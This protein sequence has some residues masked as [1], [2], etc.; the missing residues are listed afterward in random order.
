MWYSLT[1]LMPYI[2]LNIPVVRIIKRTLATLY[3]KQVH[4][5]ILNVELFDV[6]LHASY[7]LEQEIHVTT[8]GK[9]SFYLNIYRVLRWSH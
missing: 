5:G 6:T 7:L 2:G 9:K 4:N 3:M 1:V 8:C